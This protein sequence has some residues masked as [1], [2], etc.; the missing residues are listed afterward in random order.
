MVTPKLGQHIK[1]RKPVMIGYG[2]GTAG[3]ASWRAESVIHSE[4][5]RTKRQG[6]RK[7]QR[8]ARRISRIHKQ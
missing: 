1:T 6:K 5:E 8:R 2:P 4:Q 7:A 3:R